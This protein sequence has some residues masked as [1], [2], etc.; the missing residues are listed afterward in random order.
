[1]SDYKN[2]EQDELLTMLEQMQD[3]IEQKDLTISQLKQKLKQTPSNSSEISELKSLLTEVQ[4]ESKRKSQKILQLE[5]TIQQLNAKIESLNNSDLQLREAK[6]LSQEASTTVSAAE[7]E[8]ESA[9]QEASKARRDAD[10]KVRQMKEDLSDREKAATAKE[11][12]LND[13]EADIEGEVGKRVL[14]LGTKKL[15]ALEKDYKAKNKALN[16]KYDKMTAGYKGRYYMA[17]YYGIVVTVLMAVL[18]EVFRNEVAVFFTTLFDG[19]C[20]IGQGLVDLGGLVAKL[21]DM[22][23]QETVAFIVHWLLQI[24]VTVGAVAGLMFLIVWGISKF[25]AFFKE[26]YADE[27][28]VAVMLMALAIIVI[29]ADYVALL[30]VNLILLYILVFIGYL[31]VRAFLEWDDAEAKKNLLVNVGLTVGIIVLVWIGLRSIA[32]SLSELSH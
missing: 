32:Q 3:E 30:P 27:L 28:T 25:I 8:A 6:R 15:N 2:S 9:R 14:D 7:A 19:L 16:D 5:Q 18:S 20:T 12:R 24:I 31:V 1:M 21:G 26:H 10:A 13:I 22:I 23:P 29:G 4:N 17:L 11:A